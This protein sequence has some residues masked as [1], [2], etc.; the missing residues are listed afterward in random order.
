MHTHTRVAGLCVSSERNTHF[1]AHIS[2]SQWSLK[3]QIHFLKIG[4]FTGSHMRENH[5]SQSGALTADGKQFS[6]A[7]ARSDMKG[8]KIA[9]SD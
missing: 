6:T 9:P 7:A 4:R 3:K 5:L 1:F 2:Q 8:E